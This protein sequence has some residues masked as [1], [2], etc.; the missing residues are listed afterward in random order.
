[1]AEFLLKLDI[2][3]SAGVDWTTCTRDAS[4]HIILTIR[5]ALYLHLK[6]THKVNFNIYNC[7]FLVHNLKVHPVLI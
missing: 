4:L 2:V 3:D 7:I 1:M 6:L 5:C